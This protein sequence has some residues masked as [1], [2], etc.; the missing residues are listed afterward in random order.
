MK[1]ECDMIRDLMPLCAEGIGTAASKAAVEAHIAECEA[2]AAEWESVQAGEP[3]FPETEVPEESKQFVKTA[4]RVRKKRVLAVLLTALVVAGF[5]VGRSA[6]IL[7]KEGGG[8]F[9][10]EKAAVAY[11]KLSG[12]LFPSPYALDRYE[13]LGDTDFSPEVVYTDF[14]MSNQKICFIKYTEPQ[15]GTEYLDAVETRKALGLWFGAGC[16]GGIECPMDAGIYPVIQPIETA[17]DTT[18]FFYVT[19]PAVNKIEL[20][21]GENTYEYLAGLNQGGISTAPCLK[22]SSDGKTA[23][24]TGTAYD[25]NGTALYTMHCTDGAFI[26]EAAE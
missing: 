2:C 19:D 11:M 6:W 24:I 23:E 4:K 3:A 5:F 22:R 1:Y 13:T 25:A 8:R 9:S 17:V 15:S 16:Y 20:R 21:S 26:W 10:P 12:G 18:F 7:M 14:I